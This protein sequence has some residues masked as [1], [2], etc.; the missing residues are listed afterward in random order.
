MMLCFRRISAAANVRWLVSARP[1]G[2]CRLDNAAWRHRHS[3]VTECGRLN[4]PLLNGFSVFRLKGTDSR[5]P[6]WSAVLRPHGPELSVN[7]GVH[8]R[9]VTGFRALRS[10]KARGLCSEKPG[11]T[12]PDGSPAAERK[13]ENSVPGHGLFKFKELVSAGW[14]GTCLL[15]CSNVKKMM[16]EKQLLHLLDCKDKIRNYNSV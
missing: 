3:P 11:E 5:V 10:P 2:V 15:H 1:A 8:Q 16:T 9:S 14:C 12:P 13:E 7:R 4:N 6:C